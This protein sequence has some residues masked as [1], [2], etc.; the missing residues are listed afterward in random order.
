MR[1]VSWWT[2]VVGLAVAILAR[3]AISVEFGGAGEA[4]LGPLGV[5][6]LGNP[7]PAPD[8]SL[9]DVDGRVVRLSQLRGKAVL[10]GFWA[11]W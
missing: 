1:R 10:V 8:F 3:G 4:K 9:P 5:V 7:Q 2:L 6:W 11:S